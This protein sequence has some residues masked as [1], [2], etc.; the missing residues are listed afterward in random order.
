MLKMENVS[1]IYRTNLIETHALRDFSLEIGEGD[2]VEIYCKTPLSVCEERD[3]KGLYKKARAGEIP[4][5]TGITSP[6]EEPVNPELIVETDKQTVEESKT[7]VV[8]YLKSK[9]IL[10]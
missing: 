3:P 7:V 10:K 8:D 2:F 9:G 1:K 4:E 5:F 6:Y